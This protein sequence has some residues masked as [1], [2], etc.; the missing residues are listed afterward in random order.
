MSSHYK[1]TVSGVAA[2]FTTYLQSAEPMSP[3][4]LIHSNGSTDMH[5]QGAYDAALRYLNAAVQGLLAT[6]CCQR[7]NIMVQAACLLESSLS[8]KFSAQ[9]IQS[10]HYSTPYATIQTLK[11]SAFSLGC[12]VDHLQD[13][14]WDATALPAQHQD[15]L[16]LERV[17][18]Q[19]SRLHCLLKAYQ[20]AHQQDPQSVQGCRV[21]CRRL[22]NMW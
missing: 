7:K 22:T 11:G 2:M 1:S 20:P 8:A 5:I 12:V 19:R 6:H 14:W 21:M 9:G 16:L 18:R 4:V 3:S 15:G 13:L 10:E 17:L